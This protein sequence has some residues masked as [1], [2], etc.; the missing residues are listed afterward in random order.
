MSVRTAST[1][2]DYEDWRGVRI[3]VMPYE[4]C[5]SVGELREL[6]RA[7][8]LMVLAEVGGVVVGSGLVD[9]SRDGER[10][11]L[12]ARVRPDFRRRGVG[13][14]LL[15]VLGEHAV[16]EGY[17]T[18]G[19]SVDDEGSRVFAERF[20]FVE[21]NREVEQVRQIGDEPW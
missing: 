19:G 9:R 6:D 12:A 15:R 13:T 11:S 18:A 20:G 7:G 16:A 3:A 17:D 4:R 21:V 5:R 1:D 2:A 14:E 8:R 10:A